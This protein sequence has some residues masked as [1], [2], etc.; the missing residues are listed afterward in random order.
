MAEN[1]LNHNLDF[2]D[3][4]EENNADVFTNFKE[5]LESVQTFPGLYAFKFILTG[6][7]A[8]LTE[9]RAVLPDDNFIETPSKT[10]KYISVTVKKWMLN[11]DAVVDIYKKVG[12]IKGIMML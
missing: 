6:G 3:I 11:A 1:N 4:P 9:L 2:N 12:E 7:V 5:K 10:G 8:K